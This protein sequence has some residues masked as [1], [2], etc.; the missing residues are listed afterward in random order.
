MYIQLK[1]KHNEEVDEF[2][3]RWIIELNEEKEWASWEK[4]TLE[5]DITLLHKNLDVETKFN[6]ELS[7]ENQ[8][9]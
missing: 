8:R 1:K 4:R 3:E 6:R 9:I 7:I 5:N 2:E